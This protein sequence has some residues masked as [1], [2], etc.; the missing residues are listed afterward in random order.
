MNAELCILATT[1]FSVGV[2][3]TV[4]GPDHYIPFVAMARTNNWSAK[5]TASITTLCG[6]GTRARFGRDR[7]HWIDVRRHANEHRNAGVHAR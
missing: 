6:L 3:H 5:K 1:A 7:S 2:L 4:L